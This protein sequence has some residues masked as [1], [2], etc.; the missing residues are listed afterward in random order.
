MGTV[1]TYPLGGLLLS[2]TSWD[3]VFYCTAGL[4]LVWLLLWVTL[5]LPSNT[6]LMTV[7]PPQVSDTPEESGRISEEERTYILST[8]SYNPALAQVVKRPSVARKAFCLNSTA[9]YFCR[10]GD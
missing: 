3:S 4:G 9:D 10:K 8:R 5:V 6:I 7:T 2:L 1:V